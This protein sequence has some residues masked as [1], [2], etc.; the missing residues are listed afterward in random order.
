MTARA[1][2]F[3]AHTNENKIIGDPYVVCRSVDGKKCM[4]TAWENCVNPWANP[5]VP[6]F[7]SDPKFD[8]C[9]PGQTVRL[10]GGLW[11]YEGTDIS[12]EIERIKK[13]AWSDG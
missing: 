11:F 13:S 10:K 12:G 5:D 3:E 8:G 2:G 7:H 9:E 6:C 1:R 4:I